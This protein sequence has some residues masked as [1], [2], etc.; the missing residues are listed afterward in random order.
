MPSSHRREFNFLVR[1][2][3]HTNLGCVCP[4]LC[5]WPLVA[6]VSGSDLR[7]EKLAERNATHTPEGGKKNKRSKKKK[8][9]KLL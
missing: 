6:K 8:Y 1:D 4:F 5:P 7:E 2:D 9:Y 3:Y